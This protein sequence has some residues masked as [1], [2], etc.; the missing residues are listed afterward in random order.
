MNKFKFTMNFNLGRDGEFDGGAVANIKGLVEKYGVP[1]TYIEIGVYEGSTLFWFA[2]AI[3]DIDLIKDFK[4]YAIDP[5]STSKDLK[6]DLKE[7]KKNFDHNLSVCSY[8]NSVEYIQKP[9]NV[10]LPELISK[11]V[12]AQIIYIDGDHTAGAVLSDLVMASELLEVGGVLLC[13]DCVFWRHGY[14]LG[15]KSAAEMSPRMAVEN[16]LF[17]NWNRYVPLILPD[18]SQTG[19]L[20]LC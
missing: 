15:E 10:A 6:E 12:K 19:L 20:K 14:G 7:V 16:F 13:D 18:P 5:H 2:E 3:G 17:C 9:S 4:M 1:K 11:G 8:K